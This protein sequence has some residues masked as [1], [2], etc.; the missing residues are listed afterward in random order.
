VRLLRAKSFA[1]LCELARRPG[2][3][4]TKEELWQLLPRNPADAVEPP[5]PARKEM[6]AL[7]EKQTASLLQL[8]RDTPLSIPILLAVTTGLRRGELLALRW[9]DLDLQAATLAVRRTLEQTHGALTFKQPKT[10]K[11]RRVVA[12]PRLTIDA[13]RSHRSE[14]A[15]NRLLLGAAYQDDGLIC[16]KPDGR[17]VDPR[18]VSHAFAALIRRSG[19]R[20]VRFHDRRHSHATQL[21]AQGIHPKVVSER[22]GHSTVGITLDVY[23]HVLPSMQ[24]EAARRIDVA[25]CAALNG[26]DQNG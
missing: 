18:S 6:A 14:Q 4:V 23:S 19:L 13:L 21:L 2:R 12:V 26:E 1:V 3:V 8:A 7:D 17:P 16:A 9:E 10:P 5:R 25:L 20:R 11:S 24:E 22:L 15:K